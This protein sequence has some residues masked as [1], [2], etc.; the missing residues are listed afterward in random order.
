MS[1]NINILLKLFETLRESSDKNENTTQQLVVQQLEL[2]GHIKH[3]P[4][5]DL[6]DALKEHAK[7]SSE[8]IDACSE[9]VEN[10]SGDLMLEI[11]KLISKVNKMILVVIVAFTVSAVAYGII[12]TVADSDSK[13]DV[14]QEKIEKTQ[15]EEHHKIANEVIEELRKEI[16]NLQDTNKTEEN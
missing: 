9:T 14:W 16:R 5:E 1:N 4:I 2:V 8:D 13:F 10:T 11:K 3:L 7:E 12:K 15:K 6:R